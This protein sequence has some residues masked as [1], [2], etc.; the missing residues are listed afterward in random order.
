VLG[1]DVI[2][3]RD[4]RGEAV[5]LTDD[6]LTVLDAD[7]G[8]LDIGE[9]EHPG[10]EGVSVAASLPDLDDGAYVVAWRV[11]SNSHPIG[12]AFTFRVGEADAE[13]ADDRRRSTRC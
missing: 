2:D 12:G 5:D 1:P 9:P 4:Q 13:A 7:G 8:R 10:G 6:T 11:V 3:Q